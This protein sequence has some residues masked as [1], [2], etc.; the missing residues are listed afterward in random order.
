[1]KLWPGLSA[2]V[3]SWSVAVALIRVVLL[4]VP[5]NAHGGV[6]FPTHL[7][8]E[9]WRYADFAGPIRPIVV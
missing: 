8:L 6:H 4:L 7:I 9:L 3:G 2:R 5:G 1:M